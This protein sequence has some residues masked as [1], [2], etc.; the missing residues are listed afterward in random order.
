[1]EERDRQKVSERYRKRERGGDGERNYTKATNTIKTL[2][3][4]YIGFFF[5]KYMD[6]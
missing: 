3:Q 6:I 1:V 2:A 4:M 5:L